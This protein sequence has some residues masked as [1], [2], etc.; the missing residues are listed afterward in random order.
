MSIR[1]VHITLFLS[2][3]IPIFLND[4]LPCHAQELDTRF[5]IKKVSPLFQKDTLSLCFMGDIMM[6]TKQI[7]TALKTDGK[8]DFS[9]YFSL[10]KGRIREADLAVA[11]MEFTLAGKPYTGYPCFSAPDEA[12]AYIADCG[13][14]VFLCANNHI[15]DKGGDGASRTLSL[16]RELEGSHG[17]RVTGLAGSEDE[18]CRNTPLTMLR[19]GIRLAFI[20]FTY[21]TNSGSGTHWPKT[22]YMSDT[23]LLEKALEKAE[24]EADITIVLPHWGTEYQLTHSRKQEDM[25][26]WLT[27]KGADIIIG[28]HPHVIQDTAH[29][30]NVQ[31]AYS[32]GNA[33]S[34]M[35]A[36]NTQLELMA[37]LRIVRETNGDLKI[38][39]LEFTWLWCSR[40]GGFCDDFIVVPVEEYA[41]KDEEWLDIQD[42]RK[43]M[44][45][46]NSVK[47][48]TDL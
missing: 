17:I 19:K 48:K 20:N 11:N 35:S 33:V 45:T 28:T 44:R 5:E 14:D 25:A 15:F 1:R 31:V 7:E 38:L 47:D 10:M 34:N 37:T 16:Y 32:L 4:G 9:T 3:F 36:Q 6:H 18:R 21:G 12:A 41:D 26:K 29:I 2:V 46:Y 27:E 8:Y 30:N 23:A 39:P 42:H 13:F 24:K 22:N 43:M 40:P